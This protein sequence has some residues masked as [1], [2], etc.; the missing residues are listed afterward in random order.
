MSIPRARVSEPEAIPGTPRRPGDFPVGDLMAIACLVIEAGLIVFFLRHLLTR[1]FYYDEGW[2]AYEIAQGA[3]FLGHLRAAVGPLSLG[4][5]AIEN[6]ARV[7]FG[8]TEAG[9]RT[10]MFLVFPLLGVATYLLARRWLGVAVSFCVAGLL[11]VN[12]WIVNYGLQ[13]K[14]YPYEALFAVITVALYVLL[15]RTAW[16][17]AQLLGLYAALGLT[18]VFSLPNLFVAVPLLA[19]DLV[20]TVRARDRIAL[21]I[22]GEALAGVIALANYVVFLAPQSGVVGT[23]YF[24]AQYPPPGIGGFARFTID[25][26]KSWVPSIITGVAGATNATPRYA[27]PPLAHHL[28]AIGLV[29]LLAA[30]VVAAAR[31]V[32]GRALIVA[33]GG[34]L[35]I[36]LAGAALHRWP[37]GLIRQN[38]LIVPMLYVLGGIG[39]VWLAGVLR[40]Q[41]RADAVAGGITWWRAAA[42]AVAVAM[43]AVTAAAGGV[44]TAKAFA[45]SSELQTEPT[46]FGGVKDAVAVTRQAAVPGDLVIIRAGRSTPVWYGTQWLY[47]MESYAGWPSAIAARPRIPGQDTLSVVYVTPAAADQFLAAHRASPAVFLM[48]FNL[49]G[50]RFPRWAHQESLQ[51]LRRFGYCPVRDITYPITGHLTVLKAGCSRT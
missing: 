9:L 16:R 22:A 44:A 8:D 41:R 26:L 17:P 19:L 49:P 21:R 33:C 38:I 50:Y 15:R 45:E 18:C 5:L 11:L 14:S 48:E 20:E 12:L 47:Y 3:S 24:N 6:A 51:T 25:G 43:F 23:N 34:A 40:G 1:P 36:E 27:L 2:R 4:W 7:L 13:L 32:A 46:M 28:L 35:L 31:E 30:G 39:A 37:Y 42:L 10:P 29:I